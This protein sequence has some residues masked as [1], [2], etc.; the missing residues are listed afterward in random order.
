MIFNVHWVFITVKIIL[1]EGRMCNIVI[2][3][4]NYDM[5]ENYVLFPLYSSLLP[6]LVEMFSEC[7]SV[8]IKIASIGNKFVFRIYALKATILDQT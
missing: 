1:Y 5:R 6:R 8:M 2:L 7:A 3:K 4:F